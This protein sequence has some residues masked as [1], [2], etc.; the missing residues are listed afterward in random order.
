LI[1]PKRYKKDFEDRFINKEN[2]QS[3][4]PLKEWIPGGHIDKSKNTLDS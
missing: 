1:I 4:R 3:S 2:R